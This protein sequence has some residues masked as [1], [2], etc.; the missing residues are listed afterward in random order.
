MVQEIIFKFKKRMSFSA[1]VKISSGNTDF[2]LSKD[3]KQHAPLYDLNTGDGLRKTLLGC[4]IILLRFLISSMDGGLL[5]PN[6]FRSSWVVVIPWEL[7]LKV[8]FKFLV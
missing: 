8:R 6:S 7:E 3:V 1:I 5:F 4:P 2:L